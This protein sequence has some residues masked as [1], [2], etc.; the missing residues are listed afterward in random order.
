MKCIDKV[1]SRPVIFFPW[2][3]QAMRH[4]KRGHCKKRA[5][6]VSRQKVMLKESTVLGLPLKCSLYVFG[7][8]QINTTQ[9]TQIKSGHLLTPCGAGVHK[10]KL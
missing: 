8:P 4:R 9:S 10:S 2:S 7:P 6:K 1:K 3:T 5:K